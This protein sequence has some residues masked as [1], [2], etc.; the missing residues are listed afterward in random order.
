MNIYKIKNKDTMKFIKTYESFINENIQAINESFASSKL[1]EVAEELSKIKSNGGAFL[2]LPI[3]IAWDQIPD[4]DVIKTESQAPD[5]K[6]YIND[7]DYLIIWYTDKQQTIKW[8]QTTYSKYGS[9]MDNSIYLYTHKLILTQG[10]DF[11]YGYDTLLQRNPARDNY[12]KPYQSLSVLQL[13]TGLEANALVI[14]RSV[15]DEYST[16]DL[17]KERK[18]TKEGATALMK[19]GNIL[20][21]N[22]ERYRKLLKAS[23]NK[24]ETAEIDE[25][26]LNA[27]EV[28]KK[29]ISDAA[30]FDFANL[31][32]WKISDYMKVDM[33]VPSVK[34]ID[35]TKLEEY[36]K[37]YNSLIYQY[38]SYVDEVKGNSRWKEESKT[39]ILSIINN[40]NSI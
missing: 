27:T 4:S 26:V 39:K 31:I 34:K 28:L 25:M 23:R 11:L 37:I 21:N 7:A 22:Q 5:I 17:R 1:R 35:T 24:A 3:G 13:A 14:K 33:E 15:L 6:K 29:L 9:K 2:K 38:G 36:A 20:S 19:V 40:I 10:R 18:M 32:T 8:K 12:E 16:D 30:T